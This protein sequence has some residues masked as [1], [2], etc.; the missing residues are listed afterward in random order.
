MCRVCSTDRPHQV[1]SAA[2]DE[3]QS[4]ATHLD[5]EVAS[6]QSANASLE[7]SVQRLSAQHSAQEQSATELRQQLQHVKSE[8]RHVKC[9]CARGQRVQLRLDSCSQFACVWVVDSAQIAPSF[10]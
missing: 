5:A 10:D 1:K 9:A 2:H 4:R 3:L 8:V 6:L 7:Q